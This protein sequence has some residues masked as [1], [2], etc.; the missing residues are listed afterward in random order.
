[1]L[2]RVKKRRILVL[3]CFLLLLTACGANDLA[4]NNPHEIESTTDAMSEP[5]PTDTVQDPIYKDNDETPFT[6]E[7]VLYLTDMLKTVGDWVKAWEKTEDF[8]HRD[9]DEC[10]GGYSVHIDKSD[11]STRINLG[12]ADS[13]AELVVLIP[14]NWDTTID[15]GEEYYYYS[16]YG[17][18]PK[19][20]L[21]MP[22]ER[23]QFLHLDW[24]DLPLPRGGK[25]GDTADEITSKFLVAGSGEDPYLLYDISADY[26]GSFCGQQ[27]SFSDSK[28]Y[29]IEYSW[30]SSPN[31]DG[32]KEYYELTYYFDEDDIVYNCN[33]Q[34]YTD[35]NYGI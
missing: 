1:M 15:R 28:C 29:K 14:K 30:V 24:F 32:L 8:S 18:L 13:A 6:P 22:V 27:I 11:G 23:V 26:N 21:K 20:Y 35:Y 19:K 9:P 12:E 33:F 34:Y 4:D 5:S 16:G 31:G 17:T 2:K 10:G 25:I 7:D 3:I